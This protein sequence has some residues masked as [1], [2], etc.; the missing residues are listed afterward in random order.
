[1][2]SIWNGLL[3]LHGHIADPALAR[4]LCGDEE[5]PRRRAA[6]RRLVA[7]VDCLGI[8]AIRAWPE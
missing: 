4:R 8:G 1:M 2:S 6:W 7:L 5:T 3:F